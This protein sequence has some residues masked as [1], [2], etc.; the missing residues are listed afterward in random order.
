MDNKTIQ[1]QRQIAQSRPLT[2]LKR[3]DDTR[4]GFSVEVQK[5]I[6]GLGMFAAW[7]K[8]QHELFSDRE[9]ELEDFNKFS[10]VE[11]M[12]FSR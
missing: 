12:A 4:P 11:L 6:G 8:V 9:G 10:F 5:R 3:T 1:Y 7:E 2:M